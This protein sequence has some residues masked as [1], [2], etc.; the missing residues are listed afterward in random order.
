VGAA[1]FY[2]FYDIQTFKWGKQVP[3]KQLVTTKVATQAALSV[4]LCATVASGDTVDFFRA[5]P[6]WATS[7]L[8]VPV[9]LWS[10]L[11]V[12]ALATFLQV[13]GMQAVGPTRAQTI[14]ASQP[15]WS[16]MLAYAFLGETVGVQG[17]VG[18]CAFLFALFLAATAPQEPKTTQQSTS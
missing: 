11:I 3:R 12:N 17:A 1:V 4:A 15:L 18:G 5:N 2:S 14:F 6:D 8:L 10:G 13:G 16:S 9:I 7:R